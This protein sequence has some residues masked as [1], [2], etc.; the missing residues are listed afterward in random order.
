MVTV[1]KIFELCLC[2]QLR[3][4]GDDV[5][6][7]AE[8]LHKPTEVWICLSSLRR[9]GFWMSGD[10]LSVRSSTDTYYDVEDKREHLSGYVLLVRRCTDRL[11]YVRPS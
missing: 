8:M 6:S 2:R 11:A 4:L 7:I 10:F 5:A 1:S 9:R 3:I